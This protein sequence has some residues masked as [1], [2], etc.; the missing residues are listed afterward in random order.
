MAIYPWIVPYK[1][2]QQDLNDFPHLQRWF[3][4]IAARPEIKAA[5]EK[6]ASLAKRPAVTEEGKKILFGQK[7]KG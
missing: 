2:Q 6:S 5:Y 4:A 1:N 7:A 3:N